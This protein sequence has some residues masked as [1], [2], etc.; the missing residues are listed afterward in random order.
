MALFLTIFQPQHPPSLNPEAVHFQSQTSTGPSKTYHRFNR[1]ACRRM[2]CVMQ[3]GDC[4]V[5][6]V[7]QLGI[8]CTIG[9]LAK[10]EDRQVAYS[11]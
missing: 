9:D 8:P 7:H 5:L 6:W 10:C 2:C 11:C 1:P 3:V 4:D